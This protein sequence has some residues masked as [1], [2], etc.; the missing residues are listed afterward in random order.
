[1]QNFRIMYAVP[2]NF[3]RP[4]YLSETFIDAKDKDDATVKFTAQHPD[5]IITTIMRGH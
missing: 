3:H 1:M 5:Y 4:A 2:S